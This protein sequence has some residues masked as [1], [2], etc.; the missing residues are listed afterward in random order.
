MNDDR[1][2]VD[3]LILQ[4]ADYKNDYADMAAGHCLKVTRSRR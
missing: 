4:I 2:E 1:A 3:E